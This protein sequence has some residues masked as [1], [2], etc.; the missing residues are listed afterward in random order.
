MRRRR[1]TA[2]SGARARIREAV[3]ALRMLRAGRG[4]VSVG[5]GLRGQRK[6]GCLQGSVWRHRAGSIH[7]D[8]VW[9]RCWE[10]VEGGS[11][12]SGDEGDAGK[13]Q[14]KSKLSCLCRR[15]LADGSRRFR[16][17]HWLIFKFPD[18]CVNPSKPNSL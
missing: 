8:F 16:Y 11:D 3:L 9:G 14:V 17:N 5:G 6:E 13:R 18:K 4:A 12:Y 2:R 15:R 1:A 7:A 10:R